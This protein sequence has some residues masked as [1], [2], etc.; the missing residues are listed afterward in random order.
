VVTL[1]PLSVRSHVD[2][3]D[4]FFDHGRLPEAEK[5]YQESLRVTK[6]PRGYWGVGLVSWREGRYAEAESAFRQAE[7]LDPGS[8]RAHIML[9]L[10]YTDTKRDREALEELQTGLKSEPGNQQALDAVKKLQNQTPQ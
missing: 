9:G 1:S 5:E 7:A 3:A 4:F 6:T 8:G 2:L 10:L